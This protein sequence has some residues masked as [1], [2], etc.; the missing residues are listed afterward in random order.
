MFEALSEKL[1]DVF[2]KLGD[3]GR[4]TEKDVDAA[5]RE[6]RM[7]LLEA[8][9][10][11]RVARDFVGNIRQRAL[12]EDLLRSLTPGQQVIK[13]TND[14]LTAMLTG[15]NHRLEQAPKAPTVILLAGLNGS[16]KT[17]AA[18]KLARHVRQAGQTP[19]LIAADLQ[20]PAAIDQLET[21]GRQVEVEVFAR[22]DTKDTVAVAKEGVRKAAEIGAV[23][24]IVDTAGRFQIDEE[25]MDE[26]QATRQAVSPLETLLVVDAM[27]GQDA[28][29][30]AEEF[31]N[32]IGLTG[33]IMTKMDGDARGGAALSITKVTDVPIKFIG[34]G[35][36][37]E[38]LEQFY[39]DRLASR[40]LG[41]GDMLTLIEKAQ[42]NFDEQQALDLERKIQQAT[43]DLDDFLG[44]LQAI[45]KMGPLA[46]VMEM[47]PGFASVKNKMGSEELDEGNLKKV[48]AIIYSMTPQERHRPDIIGGSRRK[49]IARGS[50]TAPQ[51]VNQ[52]L[53]QFRQMQKMMKQL[54]SGKGR[55][56]MMKMFGG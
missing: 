9:V 53:N 39:P 21:L 23:W 36:R 37:P 28:V 45:K 19:L 30:V 31:N 34:T 24:A 40:I 41:M 49:R 12:D 43:F 6:V 38:A 10:N 13:I 35:E 42:D 8:D 2:R 14:E 29:S 26:L 11:F 55:Q 54:T 25:L 7:A 18:A 22:R 3:K 15:G 20:R 5:L 44:Q 27:T 33:L 46:Q 48:E 4:L 1:N 51:D 50:G 16:G 32:R 17:T 47:I 52:L 56:N